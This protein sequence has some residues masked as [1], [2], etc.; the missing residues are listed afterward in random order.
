MVNHTEPQFFPP[1]L[2][3]MRLK[4]FNRGATILLF[5][6]LP[7]TQ[8]AEDLVAYYEQNPRDVGEH[9]LVQQ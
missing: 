6:G 4:T 1:P 8:G 3:F 7:L 9:H 2:K 5:A